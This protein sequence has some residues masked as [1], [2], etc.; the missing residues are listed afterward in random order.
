MLEPL[1]TCFTCET[2]NRMMI[3]K[4]LTPGRVP[5]KGAPTVKSVH[6]V[7]EDPCGCKVESK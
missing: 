4:S 6:K 7:L 1:K 5:A 3:V 2:E